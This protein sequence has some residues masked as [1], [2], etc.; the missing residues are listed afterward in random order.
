MLQE[1]LRSAEKRLQDTSD[2]LDLAI[3]MNRSLGPTPDSQLRVRLAARAYRRALD[4][5]GAL[6]SRLKREMSPEAE[7][8]GTLASARKSSP[9]CEVSQ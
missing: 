4:D 1:D 8:H 7:A 2:Y 5:R 9:I 6:L 3:H